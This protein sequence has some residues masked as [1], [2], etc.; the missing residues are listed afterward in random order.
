M[1]VCGNINA[2]V[3]PVGTT[4]AGVFGLLFVI[5]STVWEI[6]H[7]RVYKRFL[8]ASLCRNDSNM[9]VFNF[10]DLLHQNLF[11]INDVDTLC[12][13]LNLAA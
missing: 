11:A 10:G 2:V 3:V 12:G 5:I 6:S 13:V 9:G 4:T 7:Y 8:V 1:S